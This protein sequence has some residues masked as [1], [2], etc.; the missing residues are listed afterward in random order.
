M[1]PFAVANRV[2]LSLVNRR[3][4]PGSMLL[5]DAE[6]AEIG[7]PGL[8]TC[9]KA[10]AQLDLDMGILSWLVHKENVPLVSIDWDGKQ[11]DGIVLVVWSLVHMPLAGFLVYADA[12]RALD[13][14]FWAYCIFGE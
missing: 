5:S 12:L 1:I 2:H 3:D 8:E 7:S 9:A 14:C 11:Q 4:Y 13:P 6:L 10:L